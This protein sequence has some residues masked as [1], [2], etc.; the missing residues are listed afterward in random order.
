MACGEFVALIDDDEVPD[1][2]WLA[3]LY[4]AVVDAGADGGFGPVETRF[5]ADVPAWIQRMAFLQ[6]PVPASGTTVPWWL[7]RSGNALVRRAALGSQG[8]PFDPR[9]G[10]TGGEDTDLFY[11][12]IQQGARFIAVESARVV[13]QRSRRRSSGWWMVRRS[14]RQ[15]GTIVDV[16][17]RHERGA[18]RLRFWSRAA[19]RV[20]TECGRSVR[21]VR[22][23][24]RSFEHLLNASR[25]LGMLAVAVGF[26]Y[27][28]Y[29]RTK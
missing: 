16:S 17:M 21:H 18:A 2:Q 10:S 20:M 5:D 8:E 14:F 15:G 3:E 12:M 7:G 26:R 11:R 29:G 27:R 13:E 19:F 24:E 4:A 22:K 6:H 28:E 1:A 23:R 9:F 25:C